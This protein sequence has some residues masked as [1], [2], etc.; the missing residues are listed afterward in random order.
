M[1]HWQ[2]SNHLSKYQNAESKSNSK[3]WNYRDNNSDK[4]GTA[5][6]TKPCN[7]RSVSCI[8]QMTQRQTI[9]K[10][11]NEYGKETDTERNKC[12]QHR[13]QVI[14]GQLMIDRSLHRHHDACYHGKEHKYLLHFQI[15]LILKMTS[16]I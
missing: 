3:P 7:R 14:C 1:I 12:R 8:C 5:Q 13:A 10:N 15:I 6:T 2:G 4:K 9:R 16:Y 11:I